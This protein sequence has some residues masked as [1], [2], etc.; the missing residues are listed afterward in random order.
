MWNFE[1]NNKSLTYECV[2]VQ[3]HLCCIII[4][5]F[6]WKIVS[7]CGRCGCVQL[8]R[9]CGLYLHR[10]SVKAIIN[11]ATPTVRRT[12]SRIQI[13][14]DHIDIETLYASSTSVLWQYLMRASAIFC[15]SQKWETVT[16]IFLEF[17]SYFIVLYCISYHHH[18]FQA[19]SRSYLLEIDPIVFKI[20][21]FL[22]WYQ[23]LIC[24]AGH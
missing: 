12:N 3:V 13:E 19:D 1:L 4:Y 15:Q 10:M 20:I 18:W 14:F 23:G 6:L 11:R 21:Y 24:V 7:S 9:P 8:S 16:S 17:T 2:S 5:E 22:E